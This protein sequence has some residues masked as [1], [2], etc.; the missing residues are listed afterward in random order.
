MKTKLYTLSLITMLALS[1]IGLGQTTGLT[2]YQPTFAT[3]QA[4]WTTNGNASFGTVNS[5]AA[6]ILNPSTGNQAGSGFW[7]QKI[8]LSANRSFSAFFTF[9]I[10]QNN[11]RADGF[12][13]V[14]QQAGTTALGSTGQNL[15]IYGI[16]GTSMAIEFDTYQNGGDPDNNHIA[17]DLNGN[18]THTGSSVVASIPKS[19]L[20]LADANLKY[21][22][23]DYN[24]ASNSLQVR[25]SYSNSRPATATLSTTSYN[26]ST[27]FTNP[28]VYVGF[29]GA[30]GGAYER[31][32]ITSFYFTPQY[33]AITPGT[34]SYAQDPLSVT[35]TSATTTV[36]DNGTSQ[37]PITITLLDAGG[38]PLANQ[39]VT[40]SITSGQGTL[41]TLSGT[42]NN[43][44]QLVDNLST[45]SVGTMTVTSVAGYGG[46]STAKNYT[47]ISILPILI[48]DFTG[49][50]QNTESVLSWDIT[51]VDNGKDIV[52]L[53]SADGYNFDSIGVVTVDGQLSLL[54]QHTFDDAS[55]L[56]GKNY[57]RLELVNTDGTTSYST[58]VA[59]TF[60]QAAVTNNITILGNPLTSELRLSGITGDKGIVV[61]YD[62]MGRIMQEASTQGVTGI[63]SI[64]CNNLPRGQYFAKVIQDNAS[65]TLSFVKL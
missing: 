25:I 11:S 28:N 5:A 30:T 19:T 50:A 17:V 31:H 63:L 54:G 4:G 52:I 14:M 59:V 62:A 57:Y 60:G 32:S 20:D 53:R 44:G 15:G 46:L 41:S 35:M 2:I 13:F 64:S 61:I 55:P 38:A 29:T 45:T 36:A 65:Q 18:T 47:G 22:W 37:L 26:L 39:P 33:S 6:L 24:G 21:V 23:I 8:T 51:S 48:S 56:A 12:T 58:I 49:Q 27:M 16:S 7:N 42:T 3:Q 10:D 40:V 43:S 1:E 34:N 9:Q